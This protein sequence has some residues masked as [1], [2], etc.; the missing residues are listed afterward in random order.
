[1]ENY[2]MLSGFPFKFLGNKK[3][4]R[5]LPTFNGKKKAPAG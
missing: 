4:T 3:L 1:M 2:I 5:I